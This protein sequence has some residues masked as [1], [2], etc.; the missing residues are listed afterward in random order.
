MGAIAHRR[1]L[2][3]RSLA[4]R[5]RWLRISSLIYMLVTMKQILIDLDSA[6]AARL[7]QAVPP[8]T[9]K[10]AEFVRAAI[11]KALWEIEERATGRAYAAQP[12]LEPPAFDPAAWTRGRAALPPAPAR[13][14]R[15]PK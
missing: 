1:T 13:R 5:P 11:R 3:D 12:D 10:R 6:T 2:V 7:D 9:R 15:S 14:R 8:K 4:L